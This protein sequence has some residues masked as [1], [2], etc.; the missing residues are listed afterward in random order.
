M[1]EAVMR[2][3]EAAATRSFMLAHSEPASRAGRMSSELSNIMC[4]TDW[5]CTSP[6][7]VRKTTWNHIR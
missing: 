2:P 1:A 6:K 4:G 7:I 3:N 5:P